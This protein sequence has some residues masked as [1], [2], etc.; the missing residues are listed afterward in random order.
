MATVAPFLGVMEAQANALVT[1]RDLLPRAGTPSR[2][3][4][5]GLIVYWLQD[6]GG[7][8]AVG[9]ALWFIYVLFTPSPA[10]AGSRRKMISK[11][12]A[13]CG[14]TALVGYLIALGLT[15]AIWESEKSNI[16][17]RGLTVE[18]VKDQEKQSGTRLI[19]MYGDPDL[20]RAQGYILAAAGLFALLGFCEPFVADIARLR[21]RRV[22]AIAKLS[23]KEAVRRK[24]VWVFL[25]AALVYLFPARWFSSQQVKP[26]DD[27]KTTISVVAI[28]MT[29][30]F[31][32]IAALLSSFS[33][34]TDVKNQTIHTIVTKPVERFE[35]VMGRFLGYV[36]LL[37]IALLIVTAANVIMIATSNIDPA[38]REESM[39]ARVPVYGNLDFAKERQVDKK[40]ERREFTG[41]DVGR[42]YSYRKYIAG[43]DQSTHRALWNFIDPG[44]LKSLSE[45]ESIRMEFAFDVYRTTKGEENKGVSCS[46]D[47]VTWKWDPARETE[48]LQELG[49]AFS[50]KP[51]EKQRWEH[52]N[53]IAEKYGR[54][55]YRAFEVFDYHTS[56]IDLPP[57]IF[58]NALSGKP[59]LDAQSPLQTADGPAYVQVK[60]RCTTPSQMIGVARLDLYFLESEGLFWFNFFK[61]AIGLWCRLCIVIGL[62]VAASTY[63]AG[64]V[65]FVAA[66]FLF[67]LG[68]FLDF[69]RQLAVGVNPGGG[70]FESF[71]RLVKGAT[72]AGDL[73][74]TPS[75]QV[76]LFG[77]DVFR[78][79]MRRV[80]NVIPD[81]DRFTWSTY[82]AQGFSIDFSFIMINLLFLAGYML[83]WFVLAYYLMRSREVAG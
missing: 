42:E 65:A 59:E 7:F 29:G 8:A 9:L 79:I 32:L 6:A 24:I 4:H 63:L 73:E 38:A 2:P 75:T 52:A 12:M 74:Q 58:K 82:L 1:W 30:L 33:I 10:I 25:L 35:I 69:I 83:P 48:Y 53:R 37:T 76:A 50:A 70:P 56:S 81:T 11:F 39:K 28:V 43:H 49:G 3:G 68:Y 61:S 44:D 64:V 14:A 66:I 5:D 18:Q 78:W 34:P 17:E 62:A 45:R 31:V 47:I 26:E 54:F 55:E 21:W 36:G 51:T 67:L 27:L 40:L 19:A 71:T 13:V 15:I 57:G 46:F 77:D 23:F 16:A 41:I 60:V 20:N 72:V 80:I 22:Y